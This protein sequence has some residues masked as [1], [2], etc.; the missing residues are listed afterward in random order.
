VSRAATG[1]HES[2]QPRRTLSMAV[3]IRPGTPEDFST[4]LAML[5]ASGLP[6]EDL[7]AVHLALVAEGHAGILGIIGMESFAGSIALLRSLAVVPSARGEGVG[8]SLVA[9][10]EAMAAK[11]RI[12][13]LWLLTNDADAFFRGLGFAV[14]LR[15]EAPVAIRNTAEFSRLCPADSILMSKNL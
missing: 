8:R 5:K 9:A 11:R 4:A 15:E 7:T 13:Q 10:L 1:T 14:R 3:A 2:R 6:T 12:R